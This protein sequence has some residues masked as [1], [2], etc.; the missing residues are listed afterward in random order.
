LRPHLDAVLAATHAEAADLATTQDCFMPANDA[1]WR[2]IGLTATLAG[3]R[4]RQA[5][6]EGHTTE[7]MDLCLDTLGLGRDVTVAG[8]QLGLETGRFVFRRLSHACVAAIQT[9]HGEALAQ[10]P[11]RFR[12]IRQAIP[13]V[14]RMAR[15]ESLQM[16]LVM[17]GPLLSSAQLEQLQAR[18]RLFATCHAP[19][20]NEDSFLSRLGR[21]TFWREGREISASV[22]NAAKQRPD[23]RDALLRSLADGV[24]RKPVWIRAFLPQ[25]QNYLRLARRADSGLLRL[26]LLLAV[27]AV[28]TYR[29]TEGTWPNNVD[30]LVEAGGLTAEEG[31]R[32]ISEMMGF[33]V[34]EE[35]GL[36]IKLPQPYDRG[37][38]E[39]IIH[40]AAPGSMPIRPANDQSAK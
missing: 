26:D 20:S 36:E 38:P 37:P 6:A 12:R 40:L 5:L 8:G 9:Q 35:D 17:Y 28:Q 23:I 24:D 14:E 10:V 32:M 25:P 21:R 18:P 27:A 13:S 33:H 29:E 39:L 31:D 16:Q 22:I 7:A 2:G 34:D 11:N 19:T 30:A 15:E 3:L 4:L 1:S